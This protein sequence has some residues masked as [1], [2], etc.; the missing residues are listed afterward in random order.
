LDH[1]IF[2]LGWHCSVQ[3]AGVVAVVE[4]V[5]GTVPPDLACALMPV[6]DLTGHKIAASVE[7]LVA[8]KKQRLVDASETYSAFADFVAAS[9]AFDSSED[10]KVVGKNEDV[11]VGG[12]VMKAIADDAATVA[13]ADGAATVAFADDAVMWTVANDVAIVDVE[14]LDDAF[15]VVAAQIVADVGAAGHVVVADD[16]LESVAVAESVGAL[17]SVVVAAAIVVF[18]L[19]DYKVGT[20]FGK[21]LRL[22]RRLLL[23][24]LRF[25][26]ML[27]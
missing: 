9:Y 10:Y 6:G 5:D 14:T 17:V 18:V 26:Q 16:E 21:M 4:V 15:V 3:I 27:L 2:E 11:A 7:S 24:S 20:V 1:L 19:S 23:L 25:D 12:A 8:Y 13:F 22:Q